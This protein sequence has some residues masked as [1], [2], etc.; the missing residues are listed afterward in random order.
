MVQFSPFD[1]VDGDDFEGI[2][3]TLQGKR[4]GVNYDQF[5]EMVR[6][7]LVAQKTAIFINEHQLGSPHQKVPGLRSG[8]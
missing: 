3:T 7:T 6:N 5:F 8:I 2:L 4:G 1:Y